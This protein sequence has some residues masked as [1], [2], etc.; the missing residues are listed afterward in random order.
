MDRF[1]HDLRFALASIRRRP[2]IAGAVI[3]TLGLGIGANAAIFR[4]F[5]AAFLRPLPFA[6]ENELVRLYL[7]DPAREAMLSPRADV[8]LAAR[9]RA[10]SFSGVAGQRFND[11]T[12][13]SDGGEP[14]RMAGIEVSEGWAEILGV[15]PVLGRVFRPEEEREGMGAGVALLSNEAW[16]NRFGGDPAVLGK[17]ISINGAPFEIIGVMPRGLRF[18]YETE[19]WVP[20]RFDQ[21]LEA[22][23]GLNI[24]A[25]L[26]EGVTIEEMSRELSSLSSRLPE[27]QAHEGMALVGVPLREVLIDDDGGILIAVSVAVGFLLILVTVNVGNLLVAHSLSRRREFAIRTALGAGL[28]RHLQQTATEGLVL[29]LAGGAVGLGLAWA[30]SSL[31]ELLVPGDFSYVLES[32]PFDGR[33]IA[34]TLA[35]AVLTGVAFGAIPALR[36]ARRDPNVA[37]HGGERAGETYST[38]RMTTLLTAAQLALALVLLAGAHTMMLDLRQRAE[39]ELGYE[40]DGLLTMSVVLPAARYPG[41]AERDAFYDELVETIAAVPGVESAGTVNLFPAAG[42]GAIISRIEAEGVETREDTPLMAHYR[43]IHGDAIDAIGMQVMRGRLFTP[44][45]LRSGDR[46]ALVSRS[47]AERLWPGADPI[48][49]QIRGARGE[50]APWLTIVGVVNDLEEFYGDTSRALWQPVKLGTDAPLT[51]QMVI[52]ARHA[53]G[54]AT[55][56]PALRGA[57]HSIDPAL[58]VF[59]ELTAEQMFADS[60]AGRRSA[61]TLTG[62]LAILGLL[63][64]AIGV[65]ASMAFAMAQRA[66]EIAVRMALGA[67]RLA[68]SRLFLGRA[69]LL[70]LGGT[71]AGVF[72]AVILAR[73][74]GSFLSE[75]AALD[76]ASVALSAMLLGAV[77]I[78]ASW[79]PLRRAMRLDPAI[80]LRGD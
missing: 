72:A 18:P 79:L 21:Q 17:A 36:V 44:D 66:R 54:T 78:A 11:F 55:I 38:M 73:T 80:T 33:V 47:L 12:I 57:I 56:A 8:F 30:S 4:A 41:A 26:R 61:R 63:V 43:W 42:Q 19:L 14:Q 31:L 39:R 45:E 13:V 9:E 28:G 75:N 15:E 53:A 1:L 24:I 77:A 3:L 62:G 74:W 64:A 67:S 34:F 29:A 37:L 27:V 59:D 20:T 5:S 22:T 50:D 32:V 2:L 6:A 76:P 70:V 10:R 25:R 60:L 65:Y 7:G 52:L 35:V 46:V 51:A 69:L 23:W 58:A 40:A 71:A 68:L 16:R 48:G 49:R